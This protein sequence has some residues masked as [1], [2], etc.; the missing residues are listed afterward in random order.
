[1]NK[2]DVEK[3]LADADTIVKEVLKPE[4]NDIS[5]YRNKMSSFSTMVV[6]NGLLPALAFYRKNDDKVVELFARK[7]NKSKKD[8]YDYL[9][10][11]KREGKDAE[12][13]VITDDVLSF[14]TSLKLI[15]NLY[16]GKKTE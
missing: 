8:Y 11:L 14:A 5:E 13:A 4:Q 1:M 2:N 10:N 16:K 6:M 7:E 9:L 3:Y 12:L 15:L